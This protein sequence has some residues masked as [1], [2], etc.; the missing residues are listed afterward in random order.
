MALG[1]LAEARCLYLIHALER[2]AICGPGRPCPSLAADVG[3]LAVV[4]FGDPTIGQLDFDLSAAYD[5][6]ISGSGLASDQRPT[7]TLTRWSAAEQLELPKVK[8]LEEIGLDY[9]GIL[10]LGMCRPNLPGARLPLPRSHGRITIHNRE[11]AEDTYHTQARRPA[12][13]GWHN[14]PALAGQLKKP[15]VL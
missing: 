13:C 2:P 3:Y 4:G 6:I 10:P 1:W 8:M 9:I 14:A 15:C 5:N 11:A 12:G 7:P